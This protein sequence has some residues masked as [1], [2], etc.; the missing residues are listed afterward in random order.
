MR[1]ARPCRMALPL[2]VWLA[3]TTS[4]F[5]QEKL[6][7]SEE[8]MKEFLLKAQ[9]TSERTTPKGITA[10]IRLTLT[11]G[12][13]T[14]DAVFQRVDEYKAMMEFANGTREP[15]FK[16]S[17]KFNLA[18]YELAKMLGLG[19][20][21]PVTVERKIKGQTGALSWYLPSKMD[22]ATRLAKKISPPDVAAWNRQMYKKRIFAEL[23]YDTDPN[24][25]NVLI[26]EDW[27]LWMI[28]FTRAFR[29]YKE[30]R[31]P[32][33]ILES[34]C[35]RKLLGRLRALDRNELKQRAGAYLN[36]NEITGVMGRRDKIVKMYEDLVAK[37]GEKEV[38]YDDP[39]IR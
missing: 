23:V 22:E 27:R 9:V 24:L 25:T 21:M 38:L 16:D 11:D 1:C 2:L 18:A 8:Q 3:F 4:L 5:A 34:K 37:K 26:S 14:H 36:D 17:Y 35:E 6:S 31:L 28:D 15:N 13:I 12:K 7:L 20:M 19:D 30:V 32:K 10:P 29:N 33:N 39:E